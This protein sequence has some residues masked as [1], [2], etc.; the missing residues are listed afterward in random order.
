MWS[1]RSKFQ[2]AASLSLVTLV[3]TACAIGSVVVDFSYDAS[4]GGVDEAG[5][6]WQA[7]P[8]QLRLLPRSS[9]QLS[10]FTS[11]E[12][13]GERFHWTFG[14]GTDGIGGKISNVSDLR[15]CFNFNEASISSNLRPDPVPLRVFS[16]VTMLDGGKWSRL[17]STRPEQ[18]ETFAAPPLCLAAGQKAELHMG[19]NLQD[20]FPNKTLFNVRWADG[21][22]RLVD[23]G[24]GNWLRVAMPIEVD[25]R[26]ESIWFVLTAKESSARLSAY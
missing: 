15:I 2:V 8:H 7:A 10:P 23:T 22:P 4:I 16:V 20:V 1:G 17:G 21:E 3:A 13:L 12:Y 26:R 9:R 6:P 25:G 11:V 14:T 19:P 18:R 24:V 5:K